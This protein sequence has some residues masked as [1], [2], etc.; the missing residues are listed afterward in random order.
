[1]S[2]VVTG[3]AVVLELRPAGFAARGL[4]VMIDIVAQGIL[5]VLLILLIGNVFGGVFDTALTTALL[6]VVV[7]LLVVVLPVTV[8]T[9]TRG[10][11]LGRLVMGLRIVRDDG[12]AVRF[13]QAFIRAMVA[14]LEIYLLVGSLAFLVS[15][16]NEKSK[17]LGDLLA[18]TYAMR[19][20]LVSTPRALVLM[21]PGLQ[22]WAQVADIGRLP[23]PLA[24]R[25]SQFLA[26]A[27]RLTV[28]ARRSISRDLAAEAAHHVSPP[29]PGHA[30]PEEF[31]RA[32]IS[33]RRDRDYTA[34]LRQRE[35]TE[36]T[37][38]RI[39]RLPFT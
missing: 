7:V 30:P 19:E 25:M 8:E 13:R 12:G 38:R 1:M 29:P 22:P 14:V 6:L 26:Q 9:L 18:G 20:R 3:E 31:L 27:P 10:K 23:D 15:L 21:P 39:H 4:S 16:F 35:R 5:A 34:M 32:V 33:S 36:A 11:S 2:S 17:R 24:R 28:Q 37:A